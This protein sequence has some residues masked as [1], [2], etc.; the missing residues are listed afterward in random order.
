MRSLADPTFYGVYSPKGEL[1]AV[2]S[3]ELMAAFSA[4]QL[5]ADKNKPNRTIER[6][7]VIR[8]DLDTFLASLAPPVSA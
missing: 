4:A 5:S 3:T 8:G 6:V 7:T 2:E 1:E